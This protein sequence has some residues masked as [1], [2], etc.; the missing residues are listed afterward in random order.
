MRQ[1]AR[2]ALSER[3]MAAGWFKSHVQ[4]FAVKRLIRIGKEGCS[5][6][7]TEEKALLLFNWSHFLV[8]HK[9]KKCHPALLKWGSASKVNR[10]VVLNLNKPSVLADTFM[11][12]TKV[13]DYV[14][15]LAR[16]HWSSQ[17]LSDKVHRTMALA[18]MAVLSSF[19]DLLGDV[20]N[21]SGAHFNFKRT[22]NLWFKAW[23][24]FRLNYSQG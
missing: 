14:S 20:Q 17:D 7:C 6:E 11:F 24:P 16:A 4:R 8:N 12:R 5:E 13:K 18:E 9:G 2:N 22:P 15:I 19:R 3:K 21:H 23:I 1:W 10:N